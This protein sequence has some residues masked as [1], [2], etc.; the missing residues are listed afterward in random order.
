[1]EEQHYMD[2]KKVINAWAMFDWANSAYSLVI[3]T[4]IFPIYFL[5]IAPDS[6]QI[7][8]RWIADSSLY[9]FS[10]SMSY[11]MIA[12]L[13]PMLGGIADAG[14]RRLYFLKFFTTIGGIACICLFFF[15]D[16]SLLWL[17]TLAFVISTMGFA[18]SLI[19]YDA[20]LPVISSREHYDTVSAKGYVR[21]YIGS[22]IVLL[23]ILAMS[24]YP[25]HF[26][27][28][29]TSSL[30]YR[31]GF[32]IVGL[33]WLGFGYWSFQRLP[34]DDRRLVSRQPLIDGY[35]KIR[36]VSREILEKVDLRRFLVA[37][38]FYSAG[39][40][41]IIY[42]ATI[43]AD[44][45]L[46][47]QSSELI[48]TVILLQVVAIGGAL[49]FAKIAQH[50]GSKYAILVMLSIWVGICL[51][52]YFVDAKGTFYIIAMMVGLVLGGIQSTSRACFTK[53]IEGED[54]HN[55]YFSYYDL[56]YYLS[57]VFG[58]FSFGLVESLTGNLRY[59]ILI[60]ALFFIIAFMIMSK[61]KLMD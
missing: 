30:P 15:S 20:F 38:F 52:A 23:F 8:D 51:A 26:G 54:E 61:V 13:A 45:E 3:S 16:A 29:S 4:A 2:D 9:S 37:F 7:F 24:Q 40:Q 49:L 55:S 25:N 59:S 6:I 5:A 47:F 36:T 19:F 43:F 27:M 42:L 31:L 21:G 57:I 56:L 12:A 53:L 39:V 11:I 1:M 10:I 14:N 60:L 41:T 32:A 34:P 46:Q 18:G 44:K 17:A 58:T 28:T 50:K 33:W 48:L 22:L 35:K